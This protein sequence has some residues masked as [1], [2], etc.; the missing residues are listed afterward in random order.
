MLNVT[1]QYSENFIN[2]YITEKNPYYSKINYSL[3]DDV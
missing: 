3:S 2:T 1:L